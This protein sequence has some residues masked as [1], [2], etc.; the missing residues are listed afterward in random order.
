MA[1]FGCPLR[2][3][4]FVNITGRA[5]SRPKNAETSPNIPVA[6]SRLP[7]TEM[8]RKAR[9]RPAIAKVARFISCNCG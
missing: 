6:V 9:E 2:R 8:S 5:Y 1:G 3:R 4:R 7:N